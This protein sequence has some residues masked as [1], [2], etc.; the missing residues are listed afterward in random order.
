M[1][2]LPAAQGLTLTA[3]TTA[4]LMEP[5]LHPGLEAQAAARICRLGA[6]QA[7]GY[8]DLVFKSHLYALPATSCV[9]EAGNYIPF[10]STLTSAGLKR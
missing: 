6:L 8:L 1:P 7:L 3:A 10:M 2:R 9:C 5:T 4:F